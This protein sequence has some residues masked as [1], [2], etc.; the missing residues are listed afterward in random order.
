MLNKAIA[1]ESMASPLI[2]EFEFYIANQEKFVSEHNGKFVAIKDK[3]IIGVFDDELS[4]IT[5][6]QEQGHA[7]GTFL[8][9]KVE[10]GNQAYTQTFHSRVAFN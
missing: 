1:R 2:Q 5:R 9:Q 10:P 3:K 6:I 7:L 8:V 4:A